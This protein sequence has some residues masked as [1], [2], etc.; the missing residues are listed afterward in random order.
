MVLFPFSGRAPG[1]LS[2]VPGE[3]LTLFGPDVSP[4]WLKGKNA[5]GHTGIFPAD[6]VGDPATNQPFPS[7]ATGSEKVCFFL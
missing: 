1:E 7:E 2:L 5:Q 4:G 6:C 3:L